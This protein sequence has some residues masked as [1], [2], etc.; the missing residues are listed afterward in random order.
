MAWNRPDKVESKFKPN[1]RHKLPHILFLGGLACLLISACI[2]FITLISSGHSNID[3]Q[4]QDVQGR[5]TIANKQSGYKR[6]V[7]RNEDNL[8]PGNLRAFEDIDQPSI[9]LTKK[10][11]DQRKLG[12][13]ITWD[14]KGLKKPIFKNYTD[15]YLSDILTAAPGERLIEFEFDEDAVA[16]FS[17]SL[18]KQVI[19]D[20]DDNEDVKELKAAVADAK[21]EIIS[22]LKTGGDLKEILIQLREEINKVAEYREQLERNLDLMCSL[23]EDAGIVRMYVNDCNKQLDEYGIQHFELPESDE[24]L[25]AYM[26]RRRKEC[27]EEEER[28]AK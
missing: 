18:R 2:G 17:E 9:E 26:Q 20:K 3:S 28:I 22:M 14:D 24:E 15:C 10:V 5:Q 23:A 16:E 8:V 25:E 12:R 19:Y 21:V 7:R 11:V 4:L 13:L 6:T 27:A 1:K